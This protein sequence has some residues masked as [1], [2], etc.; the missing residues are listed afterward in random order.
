VKSARH[1]ARLW[2]VQLLYQREYN[3]Q[4]ITETFTD[5]WAERHYSKRMRDFTEKLVC[6]VESH[7]EELNEWI[8]RCAEHWDLKR[9]GTVERNIMRVALF[10]MRYCPDVPPI[11]AINEAVELAKELSNRESGRFVNGILDRAFKDGIS[12]LPITDG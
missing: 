6:G 11:V 8:S 10:E 4:D 2:A 3:D 9:I 1:E 7:R 5:F 12:K